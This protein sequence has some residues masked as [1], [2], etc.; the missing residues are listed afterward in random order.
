M[1]LNKDVYIKVLLNKVKQ[2][3]EENLMLHSI[4]ITQQEELAS[5]K[6]PIEDDNEAVSE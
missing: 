5:L 6:Q 3:E 4:V 1:D 2:L